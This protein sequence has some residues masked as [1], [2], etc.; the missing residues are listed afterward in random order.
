M[1]MIHSPHP[2]IIKVLSLDMFPIYIYISFKEK[3]N[4]PYRKTRRSSFPIVSG[5]GP[6]KPQLIRSLEDK[7]ELC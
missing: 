1:A 6:V 5:I 2:L 7:I 4:N 3:A